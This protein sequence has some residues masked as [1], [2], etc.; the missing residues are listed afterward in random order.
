MPK[1]LNGITKIWLHLGDTIGQF[2]SPITLGLIFFVLITP[3]GIMTR[4]FGRDELLL[5]RGNKKSY[6]LLKN[7]NSDHSHSYER[8]F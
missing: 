4:L 7:S 1:S 3:F 8:Q 6:W 5:K 2:I